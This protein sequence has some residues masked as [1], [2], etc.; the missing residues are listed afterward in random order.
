MPSAPAKRAM[1]GVV[2]AVSGLRAKWEG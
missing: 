1:L 2:R